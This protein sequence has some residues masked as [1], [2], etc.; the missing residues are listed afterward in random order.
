MTT[1]PVTTPARTPPH[2][3]VYRS[4]TAAITGLLLLFCGLGLAG[5]GPFAAAHRLASPVTHTLHLDRIQG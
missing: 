1:T 2:V 3:V 5:Y 4:V